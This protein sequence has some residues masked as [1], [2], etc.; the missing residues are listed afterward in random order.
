VSA[1]GLQ[2][3]GCLGGLIQPG[4]LLVSYVIGLF[5]WP[6]IARIIRGQVLSMREKEYIEASRA[7]GASNTRIMFREI[8]PNLIAPLIVYA[9]LIIPTNIL[10]EASR[11]PGIGVPPATPWGAQLGGQHDLRR[12]LV[13]DVLAGVPLLTTL[14][15]NLVTW[16]ARRLRSEDAADRIRAYEEKAR[17]EGEAQE[18]AGS[19]SPARR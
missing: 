5:S 14:A 15:F 16:S 17:K 19:P 13:D 7:M 8:L 2:R 4:L 6:Y 12:G 3:N 11:R 18:G 9:T 10:F 1:C